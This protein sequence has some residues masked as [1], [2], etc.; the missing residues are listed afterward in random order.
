MLLNIKLFIIILFFAL[1]LSINRV[2]VILRL[3]FGYSK[4]LFLA[5]GK[6]NCLLLVRQFL[7]IS[8]KTK[9]KNKSSKFENKLHQYHLKS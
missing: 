8:K 6:K 2:R 5:F 4:N 3:C 7:K 1:V 9:L